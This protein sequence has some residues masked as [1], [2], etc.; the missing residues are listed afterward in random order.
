MWLCCSGSGRGRTWH[1]QWLGPSAHPLGPAAKPWPSR[2]DLCGS[3]VPR[4]AV[5]LRT[6][7]DTARRRMPSKTY[8]RIYIRLAERRA[9]LPCERVRDTR[10]SWVLLHTRV[11]GTVSR[12]AGQGL[13]WWLAGQRTSMG[14]AMGMALALLGACPLRVRSPACLPAAQCTSLSIKVTLCSDEGR[15]VAWLGGAGRGCERAS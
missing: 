14:M 3:A 6:D 15:G 5:A 11:D 2:A 12:M 7:V 13:G 1:Q 10:L 8:G 4:P 9:H